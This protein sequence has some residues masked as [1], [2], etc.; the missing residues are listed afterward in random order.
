MWRGIISRETGREGLRRLPESPIQ[1]RSPRALYNEAWEVA[2]QLG[3]AKAY[4]AEYVALARLLQCPLVTRDGR[5]KRRAERMVRV[6][7]PTE[8]VD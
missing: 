5:L 4:D 6:L 1:R 8:I 3:W 7:G 2:E